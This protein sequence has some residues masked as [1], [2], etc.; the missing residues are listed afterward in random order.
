MKNFH[1]TSPYGNKCHRMEALYEEFILVT[2]LKFHTKMVTDMK[3]IYLV[4]Y[5][6]VTC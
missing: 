4:T 3:T 2:I 5:Q 6:M 1:T